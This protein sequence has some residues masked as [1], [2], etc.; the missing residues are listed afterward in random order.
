MVLASLIVSVFFG[1]VFSFGEACLLC[2][3]WFWIFLVVFFV[4]VSVVSG[5][6]W[7]ST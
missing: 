1:S 6:C 4:C 5:V 2:L 3:S 7:L